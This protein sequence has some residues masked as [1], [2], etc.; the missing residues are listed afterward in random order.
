METAIEIAKEAGQF[1]LQYFDNPQLV[2]ERKKDG[3]PV[4]AADRGAENL[5][6]RRI[7]EMFP[8]DTILGEEFPVKEGTSGYR[9]ILDPIDGTKSFIHGV[10]I[11][12]TL[13][14]I[15]YN[16]V[17]EIGVIWIPAL[18]VGVWAEK[19]KGAWQ[20]HPQSTDPLPAHVSNTDKLSDSLFLTSEV[21][22]FHQMN[23]TDAYLELEKACRLTRTWGDAYGYY[24]VATG[25]ADV[26]VDPD[27]ELWDI[28]PFPV[29]FQEAGGYFGNWNGEPDIFKHEG[30]ACNPTLL[31]QVLAITQKYPSSRP[32]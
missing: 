9:W 6:R 26:M 23:R 3:T 2:V 5:L 10:P 27:L 1:T 11:Y 29:I 17:S 8:D 22:T 13:I 18:N 30:I 24:L 4:T 19:G 15:E 14:G 31:K 25:R 21:A 12:S 28:G 32:Q 7:Q 20:Y 16:G